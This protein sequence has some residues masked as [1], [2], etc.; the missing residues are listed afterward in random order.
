MGRPRHQPERKP[1]MSPAN[2]QTCS[3]IVD[4]FQCCALYFP[5]MRSFSNHIDLLNYCREVSSNRNL[6]VGNCDLTQVKGALDQLAEYLGSSIPDFNEVVF[7]FCIQG[8]T[9]SSFEERRRLPA[10]TAKV[11]LEISLEQIVY[12]S[13]HVSA[14]PTPDL[15]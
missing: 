11:L 1:R 13:K 5:E 14:S 3:E 2:L 7:H 10:R 12:F 4:C 8:A 15:S 6:E 9:L